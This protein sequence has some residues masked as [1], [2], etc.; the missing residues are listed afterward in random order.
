MKVAVRFGH[1]ILI[2]GYCTSA[3]GIESEYKLIREYAPLVVKYL[4]Q[5]GHEV[6]NITPKDK[7][8]DNEISD[9]N[10]GIKAANDWKA[11]LFISLHCN[12]SDGK[13]YGCEVVYSNSNSQGKKL[14]TNI[15][16]EISKLGFRNRGAKIDERGLNEIRKT[17]MTSVIVE[18]LFVDNTGDIKLY[19]ADK[20]ARAIVKGVTGQ[21][22]CPVPVVST[23]APYKMKK[24]LQIT[25][26]TKCFSKGIFVKTFLKGQFITAVDEEIE[27][28]RQVYITTIGSVLKSDCKDKGYPYAYCISG[29]VNV[30]NTLN[31]REKSDSNS[32][33]IGSFKKNDNITIIDL[34]SDEKWGKTTLGWVSMDYI[35][36]K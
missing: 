17:N 29:I 28:G 11:D 9:I 16:A 8:Y 3:Q 6:L 10:A 5:M 36:V 26:D 23:P 1:T 13:G 20:L 14:A 15:C 19:N 18:P 12:C 2:N 22:V 21:E 30:S 25:T 33:V 24:E 34:S 35:K 4:E 7:S 32:K 31:I 27:N